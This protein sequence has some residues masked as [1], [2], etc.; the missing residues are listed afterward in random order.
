M[1]RAPWRFL[2]A[3]GRWL[4]AGA[5]L[6]FASSFGQTFFIALFAEDL[7]AA[8]GIGHGAWGSLYAA[9]TIASA[10]AIG[11]FGRLADIQPT[12]V[13]ALGVLAAIAL[14]AVA[15]STVTSPLLL[16]VAVFGLRFAGQGMAGHV[17]MTATARWFSQNRGRALSIAALGHPLGEAVL[18]AV[19]VAVVAFV[20][21]RS[22]WLAAAAA[23]IF[24]LVPALAW[25]VARERTPS[26]AG[27]AHARGPAPGLYGRHWRRGDVVRHAAFWLLIPGALASP[28]IGT[29]ILFQSVPLM[30]AKTWSLEL[31]ASAFPG[32]A[33]GSIAAALLA[34]WLVDRYGPTRL[35]PFLL[36]PM[37][38]ALFIGAYASSPIAVFPYLVLFGVTTG[39]GATVFNTLWA[40]L[41]GTRHL[42]EVRGLV[43]AL[44]TFSTALGPGVT[45]PLLDAGVHLEAQ[46]AVMGVCTLALAGLLGAASRAL[47]TEHAREIHDRDEGPGR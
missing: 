37:A 6:T 13:P 19:T 29:A 21:W 4:A 33:A 30:A 11:L 28:F 24:V 47:L 32:Y 27:A 22:A 36:L 16:A 23:L 46:L 26:G 3:N 1:R 20:G 7:R 35:L 44:F 31:Y 34:G 12:I 8:A 2:E 41:Y 5:L 45:G 18:P 38:L 17:A 43:S 10:L 14:A 15:M 40:E 25:L 39:A 9:A 42:G